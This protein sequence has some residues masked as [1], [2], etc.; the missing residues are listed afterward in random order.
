MS[1]AARWNRTSVSGA[2][3]QRLDHVGHRGRA[4]GVSPLH[5]AA[6]SRPSRAGLRTPREGAGSVGAESADR[7]PRVRPPLRR[8]SSPTVRARGHAPAHDREGV[9]FLSSKASASVSG[10]RTGTRTLTVRLTTSHSAFEL[11]APCARR[12]ASSRTWRGREESNLGSWVWN[13][14][15]CHWTTPSAGAAHACTPRLWAGGRR[16]RSPCLATRAAFRAAPDTRPVHPPWRMG[17]DSN[18]RSTGLSCFRG[19]RVRPL[20]HPSASSSP[21]SLR[22]RP[23]P[24]RRH[25]P[26]TTLRDGATDDDRGPHRGRRGAPAV[27]GVLAGLRPLSRHLEPIPSATA[28]C[29]VVGDGLEP[30]T[31]WL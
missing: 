2:S 3:N 22:P 6:P 8:V 16:S 4:R 7:A 1:G 9:P 31:L 14:L 15:S 30:S 20:R 5:S 19:R 29:L 18:P 11:C 17:W 13:P 28:A 21:R 12:G 23:L 10:V 25:P 24:A 26:P 27:Q